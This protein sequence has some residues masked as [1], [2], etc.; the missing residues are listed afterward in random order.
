MNA[1]PWECEV[2]DHREVLEEENVTYPIVRVLIGNI[3]RVSDYDVRAGYDQP[4]VCKG[5]AVDCWSCPGHVESDLYWKEAT[6]TV[7]NGLCLDL[8]H[9]E[10]RRIIL[11]CKSC[12]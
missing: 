7:W 12:S 8:K 11:V 9:E 3:G 10:S 4:V 2:Q 1:D 5:Y 6:G